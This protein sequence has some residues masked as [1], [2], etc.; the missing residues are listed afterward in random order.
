MKN[1]LKSKYFTVAGITKA[2]IEKIFNQMII[3]MPED[4][5]IEEFNKFVTEAKINYIGTSDAMNKAH[6]D[7]VFHN[8]AMQAY[9]Q[10]EN[11]MYNDPDIADMVWGYR[12]YGLDDGR[13]RTPHRKLA[14]KRVTLPKDHVFWARHTPPWDHNCRCGRVV[15]FVQDIE[16][17]TEIETAE[18]DI[19]QVGIGWHKGSTAA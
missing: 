4:I 9:T 18:S 13:M 2:D 16:D 19:P 6:V 11:A 17:G 1:N 10:G 3:S 8:A 14:Q 5:S 15:V 7:L 12:Y